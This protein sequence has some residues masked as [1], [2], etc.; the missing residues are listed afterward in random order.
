MPA[1]RASAATLIVADLCGERDGGVVERLLQR[2]SR[3]DLAVVL[4]LVVARRVI[5]VAVSI[6]GGLL[7]R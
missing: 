3:R 5:L 4:V 1:S 7:D 6:V 2:I